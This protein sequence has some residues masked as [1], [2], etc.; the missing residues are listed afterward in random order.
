MPRNIQFFSYCALTELNN[1]K[2]EIKVDSVCLETAFSMGKMFHPAQA[3]IIL[4]AKGFAQKII[5]I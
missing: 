3:I 4:N 1:S 5:S 2:E